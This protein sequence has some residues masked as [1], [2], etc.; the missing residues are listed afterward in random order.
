MSD[1]QRTDKYPTSAIA[2][3]WLMLALIVAVYA[4]IL[5]RENFPRGSEIREAFK[6]WHFTLGLSVLTLVI[7]RLGLRLTRWTIPPITPKPA[8]WQHKLSG[9]V[10]IGLYGLMI[11]MP[12]GGWLI[13]SASGKTIP[14]WG[15]S[16]PAL[17][18]ENKALA[19]QIKELHEIGGK[20]GYG[21]IGLHAAAA[22]H[23]HYILKDN[24]LLRM[25][26]KRG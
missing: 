16:L 2:L 25:M 14:F 20:V 24:T 8:G 3:H 4:A 11:G 15:I 23:H 17:I 10:H 19:G 5:L 21:L 22:L 18:G 13:L 1:T 12:I 6:A 7:V 26:P 9:V